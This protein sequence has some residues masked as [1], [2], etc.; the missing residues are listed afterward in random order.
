MDTEFSL[1]D[2][3]RLLRHRA[4]IVALVFVT[5]VVAALIWSGSQTSL[6]RSS[7]EILINQNNTADVYDPVSGTPTNFADRLVA[8]EIELLRS[9]VVRVEAQRR[10]GYQA[11][12]SAAAK[13]RTDVIVVT[14]VS[15]DPGRAEQTAQTY[16][17]AYI[18]VR[19]KEFVDERVEAAN[20]IL[21]TI[22]EVENEIQ[23]AGLSADVDRLTRRRDRLADQYD[24]FIFTVT[25]AD[26]ASPRIITNAQRP[27]RPF[28]PRT[29][30]DVALGAVLGLMAGVGAALLWESL[31]RSVKTRD[32]IERVLP[33]VP[34]LALIPALDVGNE[35]VSLTKPESTESETFRSLR[36]ALDFAQVDSEIKVIQVTSASVSAGKTTVAANLAA[37]MAQSGKNVILV[38]C[39]LRRPR[40]HAV[41]GIDQVPGF[42]TVVLARESLEHAA[43]LVKVTNGRLAV[44][45]SG[46]VPPGP[47]E[48]LGSQRVLTTFK[49]LRRSADVIIVDS[50]PVLPVADALI[51]AGLVDATILVCNARRTK[52]D[53]L[54]R[55]FEQLEQSGAPVIGTV[56]NEVKTH[57]FFGYGYGYGYGQGYGGESSGFFGRKSNA[58]ARHAGTQVMG[59]DEL[60][61]FEAA[62]KSQKAERVSAAARR[63]GA[64]RDSGA[65]LGENATNGTSADPD[66]LLKST[67]WLSEMLDEPASTERASAKPRAGEPDPWADDIAFEP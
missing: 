17:Q 10:L 36:A 60:P 22:S 38:D 50:P 18:F 66:T 23:N 42:T 41:F 5:A 59:H 27:V 43:K 40:Q 16:A 24:E 45:P 63:R 35:L 48:L 46:P 61:T 3:M 54:K 14:A 25:L 19:N 26:S 56:L 15:A 31:D 4:W 1:H 39:D 32:V 53:A 9:E 37:V 34:S 2:Y 29:N 57:S 30:R 55:A 65:S 64:T 33:G 8:N 49:Q 51:V 21:V 12:I 7:A 11:G 58:P 13:T 6:Y 47:S 67:G 28:T 52:R 20:Q 44:L 62:R